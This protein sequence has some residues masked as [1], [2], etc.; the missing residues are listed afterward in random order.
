MLEENVYLQ[1]S[2]S[3]QMI[4][5]TVTSDPEPQKEIFSITRDLL[6]L[7]SL[8]VVEVSSWNQVIF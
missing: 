2:P 1:F 3:K 4:K 6:E 7:L 8:L 5:S